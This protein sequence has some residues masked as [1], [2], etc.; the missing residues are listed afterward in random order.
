MSRRLF[1]P[2]NRPAN[3]VTPVRKTKRSCSSQSLIAPYRSHRK[4]RLASASSRS[5]SADRLVVF[6]HQNDR[7]LPGALVQ[8]LDQL[9]ETVR[10]LDR[11]RFEAGAPLR[12]RQL[13]FH[14]CPDAVRNDEIAPAEAEPH[15][16]MAYRPVP[17]VVHGEAPEQL[18]A[19]L[20]QLLQRVHQ[21]GL[22]EPART[23]QEIVLAP[24]D[25]AA[26][27]VRLVDVVAVHPPDLPEGGHAGRKHASRHPKRVGRGAGAVN[28]RHQA[29]QAGQP[30]NPRKNRSAAASARWRF[31]RRCG[32][33]LDPSR[34]EAPRRI[35]SFPEP[36]SG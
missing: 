32:K 17:L 33:L 14:G 20:E 27:M 21:Q 6:V 25:E 2:E 12:R 31:R 11:A 13:P 10:R 34:E 5:P 1:R 35:R 23:R 18:L 16:R 22:A 26:R 28:E 15:D 9:L 36:N 3:L 8:G 19:S 24:L 7:P 4:S 29:L 30:A